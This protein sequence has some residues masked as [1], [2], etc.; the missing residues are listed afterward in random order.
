[1][2]TTTYMIVDPR[3][4]HSMRVPRPDLSVKFG[5]P[6]ACN[7]CHANRDARW[8]AAQAN[9]WYGHEPRGYQRFAAAFA[10][11]NA[12]VPGAQAQLR[13]IAGDSTQPPIVRATAFA[14]TNASNSRA[15]LE[16][17]AQGLR[18]S[19]PLVRLGALQ[20]LVNAPPD[21]R[22]LLAVPLLSD[23]AR[24][25]RLDAASILAAVPRRN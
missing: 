16:T 3:H 25:V 9:Q 23:P 18:D 19:S 13:A 10:A 22:T 24:A 21:V 7:G 11:A 1:M 4:D 14:E 17:L 8:A 5:T 20:S 2:P 12:D 15:T 6:N